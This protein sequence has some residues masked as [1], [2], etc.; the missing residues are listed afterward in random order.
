MEDDSVRTDSYP[1]ITRFNSL[2]ILPGTQNAI[3]TEKENT[4]QSNV[5]TACL[6]LIPFT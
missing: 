3:V 2:V 4:I 6:L 1:G 5:K